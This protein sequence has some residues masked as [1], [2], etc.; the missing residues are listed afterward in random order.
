MNETLT[1]LRKTRDSYYAGA[2]RIFLGI[3][4]LMTG[5]MKFAVPELREAFSGQLAA[6]GIP[7]HPLNMWVV[8]AA[9]IGVGIFFVLGFLSRLA[10]LTAVVIMM[11]AT[12]VHQVVDDPTLF[13][14]QPAQP[15]IP[16]AAIALCIYIMVIGSGSWS[17]DLRQKPSHP[18]KDN[19]RPVTK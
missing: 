9:E 5:A 3:L 10:S 19:A 7:F 14:L 16:A 17:L 12:F 18:R 1:S 11:V 13:P 4:F 2:I 15:I 6:A 8:P